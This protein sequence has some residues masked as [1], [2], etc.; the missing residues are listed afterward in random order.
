MTRHLAYE[1]A[2]Q[3]I[4]VNAIC[5]VTTVTA[6][7]ERVGVTGS[8]DERVKNIPRGGFAT[9]QDTANAVLFLV[10]DM[11]DFICGVALDVYGGML[12]GWYPL[13]T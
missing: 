5:P 7:V 6:L 4:N 12:L 2:S 10:S 9:V 8:L 1:V 3:S 11:V 13:E